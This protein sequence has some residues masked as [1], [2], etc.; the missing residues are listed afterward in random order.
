MSQADLEG[1]ELEL[2]Y[3]S[4]AFY[5][6]FAAAM[7]RGT[8]NG[9]DDHFNYTPA[10]SVQLTL[11]KRFMDDQ[12]DIAIEMKHAFAHDRTS[13]PTIPGMTFATE[14]S[15]AWTTYALSVGYVPNQGVFEGTEMRLGI[16]NLFDATYRPYLTNPSRN[17]K[18]RNIK[19]SLAKTF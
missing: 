16:E 17:A 10:D 18:G 9:T 2:N 15:D 14:A 19:F 11:G 1:L 6:D 4:P 8:I 3:A 7:T 13:T 5:A 12:L